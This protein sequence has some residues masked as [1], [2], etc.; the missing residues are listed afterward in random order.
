M[1]YLHVYKNPAGQWSGRVLREEAGIA[2]C[3][4]PE[5]V[6]EAAFEQFSELEPLPGPEPNDEG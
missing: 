1:L 6:W 3:S 5:E 4:S 2:G